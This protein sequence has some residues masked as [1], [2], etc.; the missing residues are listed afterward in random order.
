MGQSKL[1]RADCTAALG[2]PHYTASINDETGYVEIIHKPDTFQIEFRA[3]EGFD[4]DD[5]ITPKD[6]QEEYNY[7]S[8]DAGL[9]NSNNEL[10]ACMFKLFLRGDIEESHVEAY[11]NTIVGYRDPSVNDGDDERQVACKAK[12]EEEFGEGSYVSDN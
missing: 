5:S 6:F 9:Q 1:A 8:E 12:Y 2:R 10:S 4:Y 7:N 11:E 3:C